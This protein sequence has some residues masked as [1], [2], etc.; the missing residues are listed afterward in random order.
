MINLIPP[1]AQSQIVTEY[2]FRVVAVWLMM[3][4]VTVGVVAVL[5]LPAYVLVTNQV[6]VNTNIAAAIVAE[7]AEQSTTLKLLTQANLYAD[8]V[9]VSAA[10]P[11]LLSVFDAIASVTSPEAIIIKNYSFTRSDGALGQIKID[12]EALTRRD[13]ISFR[14]KLTEH[15]LIEKVNL[16][17]ANLAKDKN[18]TFSIMLT[19][20]TSTT[21]I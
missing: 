8:A 6:S 7:S 16:P 9:V 14:D 20:A 19:V 17:I 2:W 12:G 10:R 1:E 13:L 18:I 4:A 21:T 3:L 11:P 5:L 15:P